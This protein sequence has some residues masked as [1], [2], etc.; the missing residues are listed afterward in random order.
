M[1]TAC[2]KTGASCS[3]PRAARDA[4]ARVPLDPLSDGEGGAHLVIEHTEAL[5]TIDVNAGR[6]ALTSASVSDVNV[7]AA[8]AVAHQLRLR[9]LAGLI[10][11]DF[12]NEDLQG[13]SKVEAAMEEALSRDRADVRFLPVSAFGLMQISRSRLKTYTEDM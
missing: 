11:V 4:G 7:A 10:V 3:S 5:T 6:T 1:W 9:D 13:Y 2:A 12:I 8:A